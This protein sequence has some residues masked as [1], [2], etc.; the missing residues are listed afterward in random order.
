[1]RP[2]DNFREKSIFYNTPSDCK[3]IK[4]HRKCKGQGSVICRWIYGASARVMAQLFAARSTERVQGSRLSYLPLDLLRVQVSGLRYLPLDL[5]RECKGQGSVICRWI[6]GE[7][8]RVR[9]Q[10]LAAGSTESAR[11]RA[12]LQY[13]LLDLLRVQGQGSVTCRWIYGECKGQGSVT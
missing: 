8:A 5:R 6:Y 12:Q 7:S 10:L 1:M 11:V 2:A 3:D 9:A 13:F 4:I